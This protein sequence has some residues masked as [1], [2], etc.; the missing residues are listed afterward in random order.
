MTASV[1]RFAAQSAA[2]CSASCGCLRRPARCS[3]ASLLIAPAV[4]VAH[5]SAAVRAAVHARR[6]PLGTDTLGRDIAAGLVHGARISLLIGVV[7]T[8][9]ARG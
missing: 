2:P 1:K 6:L 8:L 3:P 5:A 7:A 4:A 9:A